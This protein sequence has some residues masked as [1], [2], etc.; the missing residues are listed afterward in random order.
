MELLKFE[1]ENFILQKGR[2]GWG[3]IDAT[4]P[5]GKESNE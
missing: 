4:A 2:G 3:K 5:T 1:K